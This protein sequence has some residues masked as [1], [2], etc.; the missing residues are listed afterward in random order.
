MKGALLAALSVAVVMAGLVGT[1]AWHPWSVDQRERELPWAQAL[2]RWSANTR[3]GTCRARFD[4]AVGPA[5]TERLEPVAALARRR[6]PGPQNAHDTHW[7]IVGRL[8]DIHRQNAETLAENDLAKLARAISG[9]RARVHC[10]TEEDWNTMA[11]QYALFDSGDHLEPIGIADPAARRIDLAQAVC[12]PLRR[13]FRGSYAPWRNTE[14]YHLA[15][16]LATLAH[17]AEHLRSPYAS[18]AEVECF[19]VQRVRSLVAGAGRSLRYQREMASLAWD[20]GY[21][22]LPDEYR[23]DRCRDGGPLDLHPGSNVWP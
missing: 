2:A 21:L 8:I 10:W 5:P 19:A 7:L 15:F 4:Q 22:D 20:V 23:T 14:S 9:G 17:E 1:S 6:C 12:D 11:E 16:M 18:E 13:F 3:P